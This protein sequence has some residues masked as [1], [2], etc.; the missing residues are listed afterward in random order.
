M[1]GG[2]ISFQTDALVIGTFCA[3]QYIT[4]FAIGARLVEFSKE[5]F[6]EMSMPFMPAISSFQA[7]SSHQA[8]R[9]LFVDGTRTLLLLAIPFQVGFMLLG[10]GFITLWMGPEYVAPTLP[11]LLVLS[12]TVALAINQM[13]AAKVIYGM[14][15]LRLFTLVTVL[16]A[17]ANL[18]LSVALVK[19][20]GILG[21]AVGTSIPSVIA[22]VIVIVYVCHEL[23][24]PLGR[25]VAAVWVRPIMLGGLLSIIWFAMLEILPVSDWARFILVGSVGTGLYA[26]LALW[27]EFGQARIRDWIKN[28]GTCSA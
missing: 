4:F 8:I 3:P 16:E 15:D 25:Y 22:S 26:A 17:V 18:V 20:L 19:P 5:P 11:V 13:I 24:F 7:T 9:R 23:E 27:A 12:V 1:I 21:V 2:R 6:R 10:R 14:G 28:F